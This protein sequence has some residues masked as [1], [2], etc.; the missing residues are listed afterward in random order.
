MILAPMDSDGGRR[1]RAAVGRMWCDPR[2]LLAFK[3]SCY[4]LSAYNTCLT[5]DGSL[6]ASFPLRCNFMMMMMTNEVGIH[7]LEGPSAASER[8][9]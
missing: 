1:R 8:G 9:H 2:S 4:Q 5:Y 7:H 3:S 6:L